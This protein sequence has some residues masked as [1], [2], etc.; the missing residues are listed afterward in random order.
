MTGR[1]DGKIALVAGAGTWGDGVGNGQAT[2][3]QFAREG[4]KVLCLDRKMES[5]EATAAMSSAIGGRASGLGGSHRWCSRP[6]RSITASAP[7]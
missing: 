6:R 3:I 7:S 1:L 4:A 5:A 2:A